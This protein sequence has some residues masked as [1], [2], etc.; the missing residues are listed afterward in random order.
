VTISL[1]RDG[2]LVLQTVDRGLR[3]DGTGCAPLR[4]GHTGFRSDFLQ[5]YLEDFTVTPQP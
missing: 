1:Y 5:Y 4:A 2:V 3:S